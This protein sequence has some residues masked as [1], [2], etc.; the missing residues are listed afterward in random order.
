MGSPFGALGPTQVS[1]ALAAFTTFNARNPPFYDLLLERAAQLPAEAF[2]PSDVGNLYRACIL[3][4]AMGSADGGAGAVALPRALQGV[5]AHALQALP[6]EQLR[7]THW[8]APSDEQLTAAKKDDPQLLD[9]WRQAGLM[10]IPEVRQV[11]DAAPGSV[12]HPQCARY[13]LR[14][15]AERCPQLVSPPCGHG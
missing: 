5:F 4:R 12:C 10:T 6:L 9:T 1:I 11:G 15:V 14:R 7:G 13:G 8:A 3:L 2:T